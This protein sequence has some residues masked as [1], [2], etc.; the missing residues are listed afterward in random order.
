MGVSTPLIEE[1][2]ATLLR[3]GA[4]GAK[5]TGTG[6][7]GRLIGLFDSPPP[8]ATLDAL[9]GLVRRAEVV[10]VPAPGLQRG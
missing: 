3:G 1:C 5:I 8:D 7:G 2:I 10:S 6:K 9:R 4:V